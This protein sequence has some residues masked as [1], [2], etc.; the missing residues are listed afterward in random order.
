MTPLER[1][2]E[3]IRAHTFG[4]IG[5]KTAI[6]IVRAVI[7]AISEPSDGMLEVGLAEIHRCYEQQEPEVAADA[8]WQAMIDAAL[9]EGVTSPPS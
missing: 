4:T 6:D 2:A 9:A 5:G 7:A 3:A 1:A 8:A